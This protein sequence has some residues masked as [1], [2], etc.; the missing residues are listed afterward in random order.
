MGRL[1]SR[2]SLISYY[3]FT[4]KP[5][6]FSD[7]GR[8]SYEPGTRIMQTQC[9]A[10]QIAR[11]CT[12]IS[13]SRVT[14][15]FFS[16]TFHSQTTPVYV[17]MLTAALRPSPLHGRQ[18]GLYAVEIKKK[19]R[20]LTYRRVIRKQKKKWTRRKQFTIQTHSLQ[21]S[22]KINIEIHGKKYNTRDL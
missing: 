20:V 5:F 21:N 11:L 10:T 3:L 7:S 12:A 18:T 4:R 15:F 9:A 14:I 13:D 19:S 17:P 1:D 22:W 16:I 6:C 8:D 2:S